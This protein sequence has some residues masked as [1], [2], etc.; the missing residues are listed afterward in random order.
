MDFALATPPPAARTISP[1]QLS[2]ALVTV[3]SQLLSAGYHFTTTTPATHARVERRGCAD[4]A[5][6]LRAIFGWN[7]PFP[8][9]ALPSDLLDTLEDAGLLRVTSD[10]LRCSVRFSTI[11]GRIYAHEGFPTLAPDAV[12]FGPD[13]YRFVAA[14]RSRLRP[15]DLLI[16][17]GAGSGAGGIEAADAAQRVVLTDINPRATAFATANCRLAGRP[18]IVTATGDLLDGIAEAPD[19]IIANPPYLADPLGRIYRDGAG[20]LGTGLSLRIVETALA[21]LAPGGQLILYTGSPIVAGTDRFATAAA[22]LIAASGASGSYEE[23]DP[24]VFG[25]EL[26]MPDYSE[27]DRIAAV[28]LTVTMPQ[29]PAERRNHA[30]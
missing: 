13:T 11:S 15:C 21:R 30:A 2:D 6:S 14:V 25:E 4:R 12:F 8:A 22:R 18:R 9:H 27:V 26:E 20:D 16:D 24:D 17:L 23:L 28:L 5:G 29:Q 3:G 10:G 19:A 7:Q 1:D